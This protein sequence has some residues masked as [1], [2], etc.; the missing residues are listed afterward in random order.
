MANAI[1]PFPCLMLVTARMEPARLIEIILEAVAGGVNVVQLRDKF[2]PEDELTEVAEELKFCLRNTP[3]LINGC[4]RAAIVAGAAGVH[5]AEFGPDV[6]MTR[7]Q[8]A[9][10][11]LIGRSVHS[12]HAAVRAAAAGADY[13]VAGTVFAS[14]SHPEN[15]PEGIEFVQEVCRSVN[16]PVVAIGGITPET[17]AS[18]VEAGA[19]GV[20]VLSSILYSADPRA[21]AATFWARLAGWKGSAMEVVVNGENRTLPK[22]MP[23]SEFLVLHGLNAKMVVVEHNRTI[24]PREHYQVVMLKSGDEIEIVQMMAGG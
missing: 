17:S 10:R 18:C 8:I 2:L 3:L 22:S 16:V 19:A 21:A 4:P 13:L 7:R 23:I 12:V 9:P 6:D 1:L 15:S 5:L 20:A 24:V 14:R 11:A